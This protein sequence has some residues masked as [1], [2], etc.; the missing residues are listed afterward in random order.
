MRAVFGLSPYHFRFL[1][2]IGMLALKHNNPSFRREPLVYMANHGTQKNDTFLIKLEKSILN[3][4]GMVIQ[5]T[6]ST[7]RK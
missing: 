1:A 6:L 3:F 7:K 2:K 5:N 4:H